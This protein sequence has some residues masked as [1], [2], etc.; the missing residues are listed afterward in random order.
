MQQPEAEILQ[1]HREL[2]NVSRLSLSF[3]FFFTPCYD[4]NYIKVDYWD[5][6]AFA[7]A[8]FI[9]MTKMEFG[10]MT[11]ASQAR[12]KRIGKNKNSEQK[13][14]ASSGDNFQGGDR[15][16]SRKIEDRSSVMDQRGCV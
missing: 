3:F 9:I 8:N 16:A 13:E 7:T 15:N 11:M 12:K 6:V 4:G 2:P 1:R 14:R 10:R 5:I